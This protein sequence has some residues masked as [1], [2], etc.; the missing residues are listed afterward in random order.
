MSTFTV[1]GLVQEFTALRGLPTPTAL[2]GS[3]EKSVA[4]YRA[5]L[6]DVVRRLLPYRWNQQKLLRSFS[7][8]AAADQGALTTLFPGFD[9]ICEGTGWATT[10][11]IPLVGPISDAEWA[12]QNAL[13]LVGPPFK[14]WLGNNHL[15]ITPNPTAGEQ[16][17]LIYQ[18]AYGYASAAGVAQPAIL[19]DTDQILF[20]DDVL[21]KG[22]E[23]SWKK[24]KG[25]AYQDDDNMFISL[26]AK[27][28]SSDGLPHF[29]LDSKS[30]STTPRIY[31]PV[32]NW[33]S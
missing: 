26:I 4:Q 5:I 16:F 7:A 23:A 24:Q 17:G 18:T 29:S 25:E 20:P 1:L 30:T 10:R 15:W 32:G 6:N 11:K 12:T 9:A 14:Y 13:N 31:I 19:A 2:V 8:V 33:L 28:K 21:I 27:K 3:N 22:F